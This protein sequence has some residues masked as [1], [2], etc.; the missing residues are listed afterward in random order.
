MRL[1][2]AILSEK[3]ALSC[4]MQDYLEEL[5]AFGEVNMNYPFFEAYWRDHEERWPYLIDLDRSPIGFALV[6]SPD[7]I[8]VEFEMAEFYVVPASRRRRHG[9][10]AAADTM[11]RHPGVW[12]LSV[13]GKN[14]QALKFWPKAIEHAAAKHVT[15]AC[16]EHGIVYRFEIDV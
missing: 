11:L 1:R 16:K 9:I 5:S 7:D 6:R 3:Q 12:Q 2:L 15:V 8:A 10:E 13:L 14:K 4:L